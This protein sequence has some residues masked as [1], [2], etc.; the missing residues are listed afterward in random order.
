MTILSY[1]LSHFYHSGY[2]GSSSDAIRKRGG[3]KI[4]DKQRQVGIILTLMILDPCHRKDGEK[5]DSF[6]AGDHDHDF[7]SYSDLFYLF[8]N[9]HRCISLPLLSSLV[10]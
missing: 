4:F 10:L 6:H 3:C 5:E 1:D 2:Q 9:F 7:V 8:S